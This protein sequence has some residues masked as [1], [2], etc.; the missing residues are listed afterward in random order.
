MQSFFRLVKLKA[1]FKDQYNEELNTEDQTFKPPRN[2]KWTPDKNHHS[3]ETYIEATEREFKQQGDVSD[4][5]GYNNLSKGERIAIKGLSDL[6]DI[7][8]T[9]ADKGSVVIIDIK[10][11]INEAH[12]QLNNKDRYKNIA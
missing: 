10:D 9:K 5:K 2:K 4:K 7:I 12:G 8:I 1:H 11:Y 6:T 3:V